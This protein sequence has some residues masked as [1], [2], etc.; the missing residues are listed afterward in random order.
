[1]EAHLKAFGWFLVF[2]A[3]TAVVVK[4]IAKNLNIPV[5]KDL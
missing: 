1:M 2:T 5:L 3:A 4:P